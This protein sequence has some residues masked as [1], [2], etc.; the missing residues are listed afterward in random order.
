MPQHQPE[1]WDIFCRVIDNHGDIGVC[2]RLARQLAAEHGAQVRLWVDDLPALTHIWP[3]ARNTARQQL[4]G[5][6]VCHWPQGAGLPGSALVVSDVALTDVALADV[7]LADVAVAD[8]V[9]EA[10]ACEL[11]ASYIAAMAARSQP[12]RWFNLEYLSA[13]AWVDDCHGLVSMHPATGL[14]KVVFFPG[15]TSR[16][17]GLVCEQGLNADRLAFLAK[18]ASRRQWL[19]QHGI[20][21]PAGTVLVSLFSYANS[22]A[23]SVTNPVTNTAMA[24]L[25]AA[26]QQGLLPVT[27]VVPTGQS[28]NTINQLLGGQLKAGDRLVTGSLTLVAIPFLQQ[29]EYDRLLWCCDLNFV[30][31]EDSFVRAQWAR[32]PLIWHIYPQTEDIHLIK[33]TAFLNRYSEFL[34]AALAGPLAAL[35]LAWNTGTDCAPAWADIIAQRHLWQGSGEAWATHQHSFG[36]VAANM[37]HFHQKT[38]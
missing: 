36:N 11:P 14:E 24:T 2:W 32:A 3:A 19:A 25:L 23:N 38:L 15:F 10:F 30:R 16:T 33:L 17:G 18:P 35:T 20:T 37:V 31:G 13:E 28:L 27:C 21:P 26:W 7:A 5:I 4:E 22:F 34:P 12:P 9:V 8:V 6:E 29:T 1:R